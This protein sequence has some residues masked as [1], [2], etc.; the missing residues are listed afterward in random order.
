MGFPDNLNLRLMDAGKFR[1]PNSKP[2]LLELTAQ[3]STDRSMHI[4]QKLFR[5]IISL[6]GMLPLMKA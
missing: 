1:H 2:L 4:V 5:Q 6:R 3:N